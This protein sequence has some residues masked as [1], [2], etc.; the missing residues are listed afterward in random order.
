MLNR[1]C[2]NCIY[3]SP[4]HKEHDNCKKCGDYRNNFVPRDMKCPVPSCQAG[5]IYYSKDAY[6]ECPDC[7]TQMW[8]F[9]MEKSEKATIRQEF[10]KGLP[11]SRNREQTY[12][13]LVTVHS[14]LNSGSKN[15][16][17]KK[18]PAKKKSTTE[19]YKELAASKNIIIERKV[20]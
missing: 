19:I 11:C 9:V 8:P 5:M 2:G 18:Q 14:K 3:W 15:S 13:T 1:M 17:K 16:R 10:E 4:N 7:G 20:T 12:G 6:L